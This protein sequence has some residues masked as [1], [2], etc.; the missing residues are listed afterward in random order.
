MRDLTGLRGRLS[1]RSADPHHPGAGAG[2]VPLARSRSIR[3]MRRRW[4]GRSRAGCSA[5]GRPASTPTACRGAQRH[6]RRLRPGPDDDQIVRRI[7]GTRRCELQRRHPGGLA[8]GP[9]QH[10][11]DRAQPHIAATAREQVYAANGDIIKAVGWHSRAGHADDAAVHH[12]RRQ[13]LHRRREPQAYRAQ[14]SLAQ[15]PGRLHFCCRSTDIPVTKS[16]ANS[17]STSTTSPRAQRA[18]MDGAVPASTTYGEWLA[19]QSAARQDESSAPRAASCCGRAA[20]RSTRC[21]PTVG[22][23]SRSTRCASGTLRC[24][25]RLGYKGRGDPPPRLTSS[26]ARPS[27]TRPRRAAGRG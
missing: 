26:P 4:P 14:R 16:F 21:S 27:P 13:A 7:R 20:R 1:G 9:G 15:G 8:Q 17:V 11:Q 18:S 3:S 23:C 24:S 25:Q 12:P 10:R 22:I 6:P 19:K 5:T 2:A